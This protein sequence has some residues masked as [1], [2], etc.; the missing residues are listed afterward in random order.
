LFQFGEGQNCTIFTKIGTKLR[1]KL[2]YRNQIKSEEM[3]PGIILTCGIVIA[4][5]FYHF[6]VAWW[7]L[8]TSQIFI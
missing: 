5:S 8:D 6:H 4:T 1:Q 3:T 2:K 7:Q